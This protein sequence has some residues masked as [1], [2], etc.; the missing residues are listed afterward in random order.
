MNFRSKFLFL[1]LFS[2]KQIVQQA[3]NSALVG[4]ACLIIAHRLSTVQNADSIC[5]L[6]DGN[7]IEYGNHKQLL[8]L[9]GHYARLYNAQK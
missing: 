3:I 1:M 2:I 5:V 6:R 4:R 9:D 7:I 8:A